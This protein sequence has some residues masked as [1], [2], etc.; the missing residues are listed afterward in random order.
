[1]VGVSKHE[2]VNKMTPG[3]ASVHG[4]LDNDNQ[5]KNARGKNAHHIMHEFLHVYQE[6]CDVVFTPSQ[7][8]DLLELFRT[9]NGTFYSGDGKAVFTTKGGWKGHL[10]K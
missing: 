6:T 3:F 9:K 2:K 1:M 7:V 5:A 8:K 4:Y 10:P